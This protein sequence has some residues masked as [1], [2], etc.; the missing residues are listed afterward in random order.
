[1]SDLCDGSHVLRVILSQRLFDLGWV[2]CICCTSVNR[3][4]EG[5]SFMSILIKWIISVL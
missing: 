3:V 2:G 4:K 5:L 1:M